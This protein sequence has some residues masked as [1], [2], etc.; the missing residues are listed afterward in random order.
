MLAPR[1]VTWF[2]EVFLAVWLWDWHTWSWFVCLSLWAFITVSVTS[3]VS[4]ENGAMSAVSS[5][6]KSQLWYSLEDSV[7]LARCP[8][9]SYQICHKKKV[10]LWW[11]IQLFTSAFWDPH[12]ISHNCRFLYIEKMSDIWVV[13]TR[14]LNVCPLQKLLPR[15]AIFTVNSL[16]AFKLL[17]FAVK[18][19]KG[20]T[21]SL[22]LL[23]TWVQEKHLVFTKQDIKHS[24]QKRGEFLITQ[25]LK[26]FCRT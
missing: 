17:H 9:R 11:K 24:G 8:D 12:R 6:A 7:I 26:H 19:F 18:F 10:L 3:A 15:S 5:V 25:C 20:L 16:G 23:S 22:T 2:Q 4:Q 21:L 13:S 14:G 1:E